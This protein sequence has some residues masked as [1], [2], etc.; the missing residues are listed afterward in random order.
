MMGEEVL[1]LIT[2]PAKSKDELAAVITQPA[3]LVFFCLVC[4][5]LRDYKHTHNKGELTRK[6]F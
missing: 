1:M 6:I 5:I 2:G 3:S 4:T